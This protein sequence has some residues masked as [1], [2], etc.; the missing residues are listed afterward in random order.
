MCQILSLHERLEKVID[1]SYS[2]LRNKIACGNIT[3]H[4]EASFQM[5][6][7]VILKQVGQLYEFADADKFSIELETV[8]EIEASTKSANGS[9]RC[10]ISLSLSDGANTASAIIELKYFKYDK[11]QETVASNRFAILLDIENLEHY[12]ARDARLMCYEILFTNNKNY[13]SSKTAAGIKLSPSITQ[14]FTYRGKTVNLQSSY[15]T[16]WDMYENHYF[17][18]VKI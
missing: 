11:A 3:V 8:K 4:N 18:K 12:K 1:I 7:G 13:A 2:I 15:I 17:M 14:S 6:F 16:E 5:Q 9:A 10:D